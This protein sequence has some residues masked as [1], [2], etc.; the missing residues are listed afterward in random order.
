MAKPA[1][2]H[3]PRPVPAALHK[4][5]TGIQFTTPGPSPTRRESKT[6]GL[7]CCCA[8]H[9]AVVRP[10]A[11]P[12]LDALLSL[13]VQVAQAGSINSPSMP[14]SRGFSRKELRAALYFGELRA[15]AAGL[16]HST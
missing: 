12:S 16:W 6:A 9:V 5:P 8:G 2:V 1:E 11:Q 7:G 14:A 4:T 3:F 13:G 10:Q 15:P